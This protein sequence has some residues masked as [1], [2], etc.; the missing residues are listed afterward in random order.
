MADVQQNLIDRGL[1][2]AIRQQVFKV[3]PQE[4]GN[5]DDPYLP[6]GLGI[7]QCASNSIIFLQ[8]AFG[9]SQRIQK[10]IADKILR[11]RGIGCA[12][13]KD[14]CL[15]KG[16]LAFVLHCKKPLDVD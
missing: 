9:V 12:G 1:Y 4:I 2:S 13:S 6:S 10:G 7:L 14:I 5:T 8:A 3:I 15:F 16:F 11:V